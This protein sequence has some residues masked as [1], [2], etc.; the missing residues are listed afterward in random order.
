MCGEYRVVLVLLVVLMLL[1]VPVSPMSCC[2]SRASRIPAGS[3]LITALWA[4][5]V[6]TH[7]LSSLSDHYL[8]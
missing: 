3:F 1:V 6:G 4:V 5:G 2:P 8:L 7:F